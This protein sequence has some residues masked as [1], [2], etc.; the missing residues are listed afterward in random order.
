MSGRP[1]GDQ[2]MALGG[3][4]SEAV[5]KSLGV[6]G[7]S[8]EHATRRHTRIQSERGGTSA[9]CGQSAV[10]VSFGYRL[11]WTRVDEDSQRR[12]GGRGSR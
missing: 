1:T 3:R 4:P 2:A 9:W 10:A 5:D 8:P 7:W 6:E 12:E 11:G